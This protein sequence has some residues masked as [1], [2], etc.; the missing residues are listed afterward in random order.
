MSKNDTVGVDT[1]VAEESKTVDISGFED[2]ETGDVTQVSEKDRL[3]FAKS[4]L[5]CL[6]I[7]V[8][9]VFISSYNFVESNPGRQDIV[10]VVNSILDITKT[11]VPSIV[12]LVLGFYFGRK[13]S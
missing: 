2:S 10:S 4:V 12:T 7:L 1:S 5:L 11:A 8:V 3:S 6:F 13:D 9:I